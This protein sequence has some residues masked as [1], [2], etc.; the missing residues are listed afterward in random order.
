[1][2]PCETGTS[3]VPRLLADGRMGRIEAQAAATRHGE[4]RLWRIEREGTPPS[5]LFGTMHL[6]DPRV[7]KLSEPVKIAFEAAREV[8]IETLDV[9][10][11]NAANFMVLAHPE[12]MT[13][14]A[15]KTLDD[16]LS[17][18]GKRELEALLAKHGTPYASIMTL[19]PWFYS[20]GIM[21]PSCEMARAA[22]GARPLDVKLALDAKAAGKEVA[23]LE[24][25]LDQLRAMASMSMDLQTESLVALLKMEDQVPDL[26]ETMTTF[27]LEGRIA[28]ITPLSNVLTPIEDMPEA[29]QKAYEDFEKRIVV[30]RNHRMAGRLAAHLA[31]GGAFVAVGALHLP[32]EEGLVELLSKDGYRLTRAD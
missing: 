15:G 5:F 7:L 9:L 2:P 12:L 1:M 23:G 29:A 13:L 31:E 21:L 26:F 32:G 22:A 11:E 25:A 14:P 16:Y 20:M 17:A 27:Y 10:D 18:E 24:D 3:L 8:V 19:Q 30:E 4:G 6:S 28:A